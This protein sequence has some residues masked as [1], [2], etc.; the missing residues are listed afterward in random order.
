[1]YDATGLVVRAAVPPGGTCS[2]K[3]CWALKSTSYKY[4]D[5][6]G[7]NGG[8]TAMALE[9]SADP[10][11]KAQVKGKGGNL[12]DP[13]IPLVGTVT[14]QLLRS[15]GSLCLGGTFSGSQIVEN[16]DGKF[17]AKAP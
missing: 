13:T 11:S 6:L 16:A 14:S 15:D 3:P 7:A 12:S 4:K 1:M 10:K 5:K 17:K 8:V 2:G 9:S